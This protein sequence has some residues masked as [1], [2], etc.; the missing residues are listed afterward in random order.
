[1]S[2][3][4]YIFRDDTIE[5]RASA[6][7]NI[8]AAKRILSLA[9]ITEDNPLYKKY[10]GLTARNVHSTFLYATY[11]DTIEEMFISTLKTPEMTVDQY[12]QITEEYYRNIIE[13]EQVDAIGGFAG[14]SKYEVLKSTIDTTVLSGIKMRETIRPNFPKQFY[15]EEGKIRP[16]IVVE[17]PYEQQEES[18]LGMIRNY[19]SRHEG[20]EFDRENNVV[21]VNGKPVGPE[22]FFKNKREFL[23]DKF[24]GKLSKDE[25]LLDM[26]DEELFDILRAGTYKDFLELKKA[27][28]MA[29]DKKNEALRSAIADECIF[30]DL[31]QRMELV[32]SRATFLHQIKDLAYDYE[33]KSVLV[34]REAEKDTLEIIDRVLFSVSPYDVA[35]QSTFRAW[36]SCMNAVGCNHRY[37]DDAIGIGSIVAYG[38]DSK[39]PR[40][41]LSRLL[42]QPYENENH[43]FAYKVNPRIYGH[44]NIGFR[45]VVNSV[46]ENYFNEGKEGYFIFNRNKASDSEGYLYNDGGTEPFLIIHPDENGVVDL[47][48][49]EDVFEF[50]L[51]QID[52]EEVKKIKSKGRVVAREY[53]LLDNIDLSEVGELVL[54][55]VGRIG[56]NVKLPNK[57]VVNGYVPNG[58]DFREVEDMQIRGH[59]LLTNNMLLPDK[60]NVETG[61][62][63]D[64]KLPSCLSFDEK[65]TYGFNNI[66]LADESVKILGKVTCTGIITPDLDFS[67]AESV[68]LDGVTSMSSNVKLGKSVTCK[69]FVPSELDFTGVETLEF[70]HVAYD[71]RGKNMPPV[72]YCRGMTSG[73]FSDFEKIILNRDANI[74]GI[75]KFPKEVQFNEAATD[76][77]ERVVTDHIIFN[78]VRYII[79]KKISSIDKLTCIGCV[80]GDVDYSNVGTLEL[81]ER[82]NFGKNV[83]LPSNVVIEDGITLEG[84]LPDGLD[85]SKQ[86]EVVIDGLNGLG[87]NVKLPKK[88]IVG[89]G[90]LGDVDLR[91]VDALVLR[92]IE[93]INEDVKLPN[94]VEIEGVNPFVDGNFHGVE[95]VIIKEDDEIILFGDRKLPDHVIYHAQECSIIRDIGAKIF[96][97]DAK[98]IKW[99]PSG[100]ETL[101]LTEKEI[102]FDNT[103][104]SSNI[105]FVDGVIISGGVSGKINLSEVNDLTLRDFNVD[106]NVVL[107]RKVKIDGESKVMADFSGVD[108]LVLGGNIYLGYDVKFPLNVRFEDG[109][110]L[111]GNIPEGTDL[112]GVKGLRL[113]GDISLNKNVKLPQDVQ[114]DDGVVLS[115]NIPEGLDLRY[116]K[117]LIFSNF[118]DF[119]EDVRLPE[120][121]KF[122]SSSG[123][124]ALKGYIPK[125]VDLTRVDLDK[126]YY[127]DAILGGD[128]P[129]GADLTDC[130]DIKLVGDVKIGKNVK[131]RIFTFGDCSLARFFGDV[132][133]SSKMMNADFS[134]ATSIEFEDCVEF[135]AD[136]KG[137]KNKNAH[138]NGTVVATDIKGLE[139]LSEYNSDDA[140]VLYCGDVS[141]GCELPDSIS[142]IAI[143]DME[144]KNMLVVLKDENYAQ[145]LEKIKGVI[146]EIIGNGEINVRIV[147]RKEFCERFGVSF[148]SMD[149]KKEKT[150]RNE[151]LMAS[152]R[153]KLDGKAGKADETSSKQCSS[154]VS[155]GVSNMD[156]ER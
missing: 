125:E 49:F 95:T 29:K 104:V 26:E 58:A 105:E 136:F 65:G 43:E 83:V 30:V 126:V 27:R 107:P 60:V 91:D 53:L 142:K 45:N 81:K 150:Q 87:K 100:V 72:V 54:R 149:E 44:E 36:K 35:T 75:I 92:N 112:S 78:N 6:E 85:I 118:V 34:R 132:V 129:D 144:Q 145:E 101:I 124:C 51:S 38:Y 110:V 31:Q 154:E 99:V 42:I 97:T 13:K 146:D 12:E 21:L 73:D 3:E 123:Q 143:V 127:F 148:A 4:K 18:A 46:V 89:K 39:N 147:G 103:R 68:I 155:S 50:N 23:E 108:E 19:A 93:T 90:I 80:P 63:I 74:N 141:R 113:S 156:I 69:R 76:N 120:D 70:E 56:E 55:D 117:G 62:I 15:D 64:G 32:D 24:L 57:V 114:F 41:K 88:V 8:E 151:S 1:M 40:M 67:N 131:T 2:K 48:Q 25:N 152:V 66:F 138:F 109:I 22:K 17:I 79:D 153:A 7:F 77:L 135:G 5:R 139:K 84:Y 33:A 37:V 9:G 116:V 140:L 71:G 47:S 122:K 137:P 119:A 111:S 10:F 82:I 98:S 96:E 115:G 133:V 106:E 16:R 130:T 102:F 11:N 14:A 52:F 28:G 128:I 20:I 86:S 61:A 59:V 121:V 94:V 134:E